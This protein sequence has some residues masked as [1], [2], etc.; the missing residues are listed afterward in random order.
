MNTHYYFADGMFGLGTPELIIIIVILLVL[1]GGK[2]LPELA[3]S[4]GSSVTEL[5]KG[6]SGESS[7]ASGATTAARK[8]SES[9]S[10]KV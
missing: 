8:P 6:V 10:D 7:V 9:S 3:K 1:F 4:I 5:R 2:K